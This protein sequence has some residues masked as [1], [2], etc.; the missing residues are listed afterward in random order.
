MPEL[1]EDANGS[2]LELT[3]G[4]ELTIRLP[5]NRMAGF[6]WQ[7]AAAE[8]SICRLIDET[9][10]AGSPLSLFCTRPPIPGSRLKTF[11]LWAVT[12]ADAGLLLKS[13]SSFST[14]A[15]PALN[16]SALPAK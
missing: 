7:L 2:E 13:Y 14:V 15:H 3:L 9:F 16:A 10:A 6:Q 4:E 5:E 1:G 11:S 8:N 12:G